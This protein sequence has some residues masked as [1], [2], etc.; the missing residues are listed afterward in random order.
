METYPKTIELE[1][2]TT[3]SLE[4]MTDDDLPDLIA[5]FQSLPEEDRLYLRSD[6]T[7]PENVRRRFGKPDYDRM[8]PLLARA[9]GKIIGIATIWRASFGWTRDLGEVRICIGRD[10]QQRGLATKLTRELFF[11]AL[12]LKLYKLQA[13]LMDTQKSAIAAFERMG[14]RLEATLRKQVTDIKGL[15]RDLVIMT[16]DVEDLWNLVEDHVQ[17]ADFR[18][19]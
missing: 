5:F 2:G 7:D 9:G 15:R 8:F 4:I 3:I 1:D 10:Y 19:H 16:L 6:T 18:M 12:K 14:F 17:T 11:Q 13:E